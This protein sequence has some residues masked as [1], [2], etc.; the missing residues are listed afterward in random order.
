[1]GF[2]KYNFDQSSHANNQTDVKN[3]LAENATDYFDEVTTLAASGCYSVKCTK[4][5]ASLEFATYNGAFRDA[6]SNY[7]GLKVITSSGGT[8]SET[9]TPYDSQAFNC[10]E[11]ALK[12]DAGIMLYMSTNRA[13]FITKSNSGTTSVYAKW[14]K[15]STNETVVWKYADL[16]NSSTI[17]T[18]DIS[19]KVTLEQLTALVPFLFP[20]G[21]Y[22]TNLFT[23][24]YS[25]YKGTTAIVD[26]DGTKYATDGYVALSE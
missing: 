15:G 2:V 22:S 7:T 26:I 6:Y 1:M 12:S 16:I 3:W 8:S 19:A 17:G 23:Q 25:Q 21:V 20:D 14:M 24:V 18:A 9:S 5:T 13:I 11:Y 4:G 10:V